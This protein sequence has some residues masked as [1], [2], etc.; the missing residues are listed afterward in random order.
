VSSTNPNHHKGAEWVQANVRILKGRE[1]SPLG[2]QVADLLGY[3]FQ[4]IYHLKNLHKVAW[5]REHEIA[6]NIP[7]TLSTYDDLLLTRLVFLSHHMALRCDV[8]AASHG[9]LRLCFHP[10]KR[11]GGFWERH[12]TLSEAVTRF[13]ETFD[14]LEVREAPVEGGE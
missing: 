3:L 7:C 12:P 11:G 5:D 4:G 13:N 2:I 10:R 1:M 9:T 6:V 8:Q 14:F